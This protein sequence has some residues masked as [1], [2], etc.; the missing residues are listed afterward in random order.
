[1]SPP[2]LSS[3]PASH[4]VIVGGSFA[5]CA[6]AQAAVAAGLRVTLVEARDRFIS[7]FGAVRAITTVGF[8]EAHMLAPYT[9]LFDAGSDSRVVR[10]RATGVDVAAQT[11]AYQPLD[12]DDAQNAGAEVALKFDF[13]LLAT[14]LVNTIPWRYAHRALDVIRMLQKNNRPHSARTR[15]L[16]FNVLC[17][18]HPSLPTARPRRPRNTSRCYRHRVPRSPPPR[19]SSLSAAARVASS[20]PARSRTLSPRARYSLHKER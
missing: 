20:S 13:L 7:P 1:L 14:G 4:L 16:S 15:L 18:P 10:G 9:K 2:L 3:Q 17:V 6:A 12:G 11:L 8:A 5:G 19:R